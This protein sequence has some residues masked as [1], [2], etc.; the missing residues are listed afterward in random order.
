VSTIFFDVDTQLDFLVPA[1]ALYARG[2]ESI[3]G[4]LAAL[5]Q[6]ALRNGIGLVSTTDAHLTNDPEFRVW[7]PHCVA[8]TAG[9]QKLRATLAPSEPLIV[10][11]TPMTIAPE[12]VHAAQQ[13]IIEKQHTDCF[14]NPN[15]LSVLDS[16]QPER[17]LVYGLFTEVCV[18]E[19]ATGLLRAGKRVEIV[20]DAIWPISPEAG[21]AALS[22]LVSA[23][24]RLTRAAE[25]PA[26]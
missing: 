7:P 2:A 1:G 9:Q 13:I 19:A 17:V 11:S 24:A 21:A 3:A 26:A 15:L 8:G 25:I 18:L 22:N 20:E 10:S 4:T 14:T 16:L 6:F 5:T 23:G 12:S